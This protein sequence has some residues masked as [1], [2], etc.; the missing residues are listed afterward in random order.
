[1]LS[2]AVLSRIV[3]KGIAAEVASGEKVIVENEL[4]LIKKYVPYPTGLGRR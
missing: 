2:L 4:A 3:S 1:M